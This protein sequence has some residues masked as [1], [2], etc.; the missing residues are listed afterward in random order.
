MGIH[1]GIG[2]QIKL[3]SQTVSNAID[4]VIELGQNPIPM[5]R[6]IAAMLV[7]A[8]PKHI[9]EQED[10]HGKRWTPLKASTIEIKRRLGYSTTLALVRTG[11]LGGSFSSKV[12][13]S[14]I[15]VGTP[16]PY[17]PVQFFGTEGLSSTLGVYAISKTGGV[18]I[19]PREFLYVNEEEQDEIC[20]ITIEY[21]KKAVDADPVIGGWQ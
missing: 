21:M 3:E 12:T 4:R 6:A 11:D 5:N 13:G 1:A 18:T 7:S 2:I 10:E 16:I 9:S 8:Q 20:N 17:A 15:E 19:P 14:E